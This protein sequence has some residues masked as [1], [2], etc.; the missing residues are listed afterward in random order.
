MI[1]TSVTT[2][3]PS[4]LQIALNDIEVSIENVQKLMKELQV[5]R[6]CCKMESLFVCTTAFPVA[7]QAE[8]TKMVGQVGEL[9]K[10]KLDVS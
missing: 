3:C 2:D 6:S 4:A 8:C 10:G 7:L 1:R 9:A 5:C